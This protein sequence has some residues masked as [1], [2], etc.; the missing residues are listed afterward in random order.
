MAE[1]RKDEAK[2]RVRNA[3]RRRWWMLL[4][5]S[6]LLVAACGGGDSAADTSGA[7]PP[8]APASS[9]AATPAPVMAPKAPATAAKI[10]NSVGDRA[11]DF[12]LATVGGGEVT[13]ADF[14]GQ[15]LVIYFFATW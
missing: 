5:I 14:Q 1:Y 3:L 10:G 7:S 4:G 2:D 12:R 11:P 15:P 9:A 13:L 8:A 6:L